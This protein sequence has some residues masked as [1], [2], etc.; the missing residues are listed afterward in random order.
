MGRKTRRQI[1]NLVE[2]LDDVPVAVEDEAR[3][4]RSLGIDIP[5][6]AKKIRA[7][8]EEADAQDREHRYH[9]ARK[10]YASEVDRLEQQ[11]DPAKLDRAALRATFRALMARVPRGTQLAAHFHK[12]ESARDEALVEM[13][14]SLRHLLG[15]DDPDR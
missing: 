7:K 2:A 3:D 15:E 6:L 4:V 12:Y 10:A 9:E 13:I 11:P 1:E 5:A 8:V 14:R